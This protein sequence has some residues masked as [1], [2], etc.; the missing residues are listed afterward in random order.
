[1]FVPSRELVP[2]LSLFVL[3]LTQKKEAVGVGTRGGEF[4]GPRQ[5]AHRKALDTCSAFAGPQSRYV[6]TTASLTDRNPRQQPVK[7]NM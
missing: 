7:K 6:L 2:V 3:A 1:M 4:R 5:R